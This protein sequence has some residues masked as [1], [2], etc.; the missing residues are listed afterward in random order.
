ME[1]KSSMFPAIKAGLSRSGITSTIATDI[2]DSPAKLG[3][4]GVSSLYHF[5]GTS[6]KSYLIEQIFWLNP[7]G[8]VTTVC[9]EKTVLDADIHGSLW[10][11][12]FNKMSKYVDEYSWIYA[13]LKYNH[14][15]N[16]KLTIKYEELLPKRKYDELIM[17]KVLVY[18][19]SSSELNAI[20]RIRLS[21]NI[22][23]TSDLS[24]TNGKEIDIIFLLSKTSVFTRNSSEWPIKHR[25]TASDYTIWSRLLQLL[26][27]EKYGKVSHQLGK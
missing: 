17:S 13:T 2:K 16:I 1:Y 7:L 4:A 23:N 8:K 20:N 25:V 18:F 26:L 11:M 27:K 21:H 15:H 5:M 14:I 12:P 19:K 10:T 24:T 6:R 22:V 9:I 3:C